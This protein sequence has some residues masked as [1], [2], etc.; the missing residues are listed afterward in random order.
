MNRI[1]TTL[2]YGILLSKYA[3]VVLIAGITASTGGMAG[4]LML[5]GLETTE[6]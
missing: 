6:R 5:V 1:V 3:V 4:D 2:G